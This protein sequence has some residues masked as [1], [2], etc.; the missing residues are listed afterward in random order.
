MI[1]IYSEAT[2]IKDA[3]SININ[4]PFKELFK[5]SRMETR[6][7]ASM[8]SNVNINRLTNVVDLQPRT[9]GDSDQAEMK[10]ALEMAA[11]IHGLNETLPNGTAVTDP[12]L[13]PTITLTE[14]NN[15]QSEGHHDRVRKIKDT[16]NRKIRTT[17]FIDY[18]V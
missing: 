11:N 2:I 5:M 4:F 3:E 9:G 13:T 18:C 8:A 16:N 7:I 1:K 10:A 6:S 17:F 14:D 15:L 12:F